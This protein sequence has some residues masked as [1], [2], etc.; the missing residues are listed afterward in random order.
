[1][2]LIC[3]YLLEQ[4]MKKSIN[5]TVS[6]CCLTPQA[7]RTYKQARLESCALFQAEN[8]HKYLRDGNVNQDIRAIF[9]F[10]NFG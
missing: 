9:Y 7:A 2:G 10:Q 8:T 4:K 3:P 6:N 1:M 5:E